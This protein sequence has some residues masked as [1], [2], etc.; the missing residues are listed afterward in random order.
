MDAIADYRRGI[1]HLTVR[2][3]MAEEQ[4]EAEQQHLDE[5]AA[6]QEATVEARTIVQ[7]IAQTLQQRAHS[8]IARVV[9]LCLESVFEDPY[10]FQIRFEQKRGKTEAKLVFVRGGLE[11]DEPM[12]EVG[13]GVLD[14]ASLALR[15]ACV[16]LSRP[17]K[18]RLLVLDEPWKNIRGQGNRQ[19]TREMLSRLASEMGIQFVINTDIEEYS[20]GSVVRMGEE[21][22]N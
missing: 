15:V 11:L 8:Q 20:L 1:D 17:P 4:V 2:R 13:G 7:G 6:E 14:V 21:R 5:L 22:T 16:L 9:S 19:R 12:A 18:R 10:E 3:H